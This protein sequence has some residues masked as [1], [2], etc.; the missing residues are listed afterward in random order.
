MQCVGLEHRFQRKVDS[1]P[2]TGVVISAGVYRRLIG[3]TLVLSGTVSKLGLNG[4]IPRPLV[5]VHSGKTA[6]IRSGCWDSSVSR[7][8]NLFFGG[9][10]G[11]VVAIA[12]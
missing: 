3:K 9:S 6:M 1:A 12:P 10:F 7:P 8:T 11:D 4:R 2:G 5:V